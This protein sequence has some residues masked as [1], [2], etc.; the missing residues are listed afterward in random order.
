MRPPTPA[1]PKAR[2][3]ST[4][5]PPDSPRSTDDFSNF[6][7]ADWE[8]SLADNVKVCFGTYVPAVP[9]PEQ[10]IT[11]LAND[12]P[13]PPLLLQHSSFGFAPQAHEGV[14]VASMLQDA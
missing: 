9:L 5:S 8:D 13:A 7:D 1:A 6:S 4:S 3:E 2:A 14:S 12:V 10:W 11:E